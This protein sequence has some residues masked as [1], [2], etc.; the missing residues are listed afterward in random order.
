MICGLFCYVQALKNLPPL[1]DLK[2]ENTVEENSEIWINEK[3]YNS[4]SEI[5]ELLKTVDDAGQKLILFEKL[6]SVINFF[7]L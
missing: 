1:C 3:T 6:N 2:Y 7:Y 5:I 4:I